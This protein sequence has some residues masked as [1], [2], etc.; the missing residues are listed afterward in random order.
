[1]D[2]AGVVALVVFVLIIVAVI[3]YRVGYMWSK[4]ESQNRDQVLEAEWRMLPTDAPMLPRWRR[5]AGWV[6]YILSALWL[7]LFLALAYWY[8]YS[9]GWIY[10]M[11][12]WILWFAIFLGV[13]GL[14]EWCWK[15]SRTA[16]ANANEERPE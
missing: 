5:V 6:A 7:C 8:A 3:A 4:V 15:P 1:M 9:W 12:V 14:A 11:V 2:V 13:I 10:L 16:Q